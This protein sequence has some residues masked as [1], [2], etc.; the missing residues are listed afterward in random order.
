MQLRKH[1]AVSSHNAPSEERGGTGREDLAVEVAVVVVGG[2]RDLRWKWEV[3]VVV[4]VVWSPHKTYNDSAHW[5]GM[6][7]EEERENASEIGA[8]QHFLVWSP[9]LGLTL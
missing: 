2:S 8:V 3:V 9:P 6:G 1:V 5:A 7:R 4:V